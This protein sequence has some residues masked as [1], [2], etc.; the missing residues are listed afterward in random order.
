MKHLAGIELSETE[1]VSLRDLCSADQ[2]FPA[3]WG[4]WLALMSEA[5]R[6][7]QAS[8]EIKIDLETFRRWCGTVAVIPSLDALRAYAIL[9]RRDLLHDS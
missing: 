3:T 9:V 7:A 6:L 5:N 1:Y 4:A 8:P 2:H